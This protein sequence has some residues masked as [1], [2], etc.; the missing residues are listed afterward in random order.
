MENWKWIKGEVL[1]RQVEGRWGSIAGEVPKNV[2]CFSTATTIYPAARGGNKWRLGMAVPV[3][4]IIFGGCDR[5]SCKIYGGYRGSDSTSS[6]T[7]HLDLGGGSK[8]EL[9]SG[10]CLDVAQSKYDR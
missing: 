6:A 1:G 2:L 8:W 7:R 10:E 3:E 9:H 4:E 5:H